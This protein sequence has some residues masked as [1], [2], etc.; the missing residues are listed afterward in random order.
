[1]SQ[2]PTKS[3]KESTQKMNKQASGP[4][5][6]VIATSSKGKPVT[7]TKIEAP[8]EQEKEDAEKIS[9]QEFKNHPIEHLRE[10]SQRE[11]K[12]EGDQDEIELEYDNMTESDIER[13]VQKMKPEQ[14]AHFKE[15][16]DLLTIQ[17]R[18][19][20]KIPTMGHL[21]QTYISGR[22]PGI[23]SDI[24]ERHAEMETPEKQ[25]LHKI[26]AERV[27]TLITEHDRQI[28]RRQAIVRPGWRGIT[29]SIDPY[30]DVEVYE[31][32]IKDKIVEVITLTDTPRKKIEDTT[33]Q[34]T[35]TSNVQTST[36]VASTSKEEK[37]VV[38][39]IISENIAKA[40][41]VDKD[42]DDNEHDETMS[43]SSTSTADYDRDEVEDLI[44]KIASCH[45]ALAKHYADINQ[46]VPHMSKTQLA[47]YLGKIPIIP[48]IKPEGG[49]V[50]KIYNPQESSDNEH[51]FP[52]AGE[53]WEDRD[54]PK[55]KLQWSNRV[56]D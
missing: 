37:V 8:V 21:V 28:P 1:M 2:K 51:L 7:I 40:Y 30:E 3:V 10:A 33:F 22:Y 24:V 32:D 14:R 23:P 11:Y 17:A 27:D 36:P 45:T 44:E 15:V 16:K 46:V 49:P 54:Q 6:V 18:L 31:V 13:E 38:M 53:T 25:D 29:M 41:I 26:K 19:K 12:V 34:K 56:R 4:E 39:D 43:I 20:G 50:T 52:V 9:L 5:E 55:I 48:L 35:I 42:E 47:T